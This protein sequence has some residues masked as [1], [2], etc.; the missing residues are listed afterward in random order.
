MGNILGYLVSASLK[1]I[2]MSVHHFLFWLEYPTCTLN[3]KKHHFHRRELG[4]WFHGKM[5]T[6]E[7]FCAISTVCSVEKQQ[8]LCHAEFFS[9][10]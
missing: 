1:V 4:K 2:S 5:A 3:T 6:C 9:S 8:I 10:K 7:C